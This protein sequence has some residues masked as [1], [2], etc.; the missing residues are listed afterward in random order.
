MQSLGALAHYDFNQAGATSYEQAFLTIRRLGLDSGAVEQQFHRMVF[1][2]VARNHDD[3]VKN[4]AFL[5]D[6]G[7]RWQLSPAFDVTY[8][9]QPGGRWTSQHQMSINGKRDGFAVRDLREC[10]STVSMKQ[11][12]AE[13]ILDRV[14][15]AVREWSAFAD[16]AGVDQETAE[17]I[18]RA[19]RLDL[20]SG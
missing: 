16:A 17:R 1:N 3:H 6:R 11:G 12:A 10:A 13:R 4:I 14:Y 18:R 8:A 19:H 5:M 20:P 7:G 9:Y 15:G 2:V